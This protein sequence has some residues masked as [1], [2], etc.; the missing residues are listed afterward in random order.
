MHTYMIIIVV[1]EAI[2]GHSR[3]RII[4]STTT[5]MTLIR[6]AGGRPSPRRAPRR[7]RRRR[8][9]AGRLERGPRGS[10][11]GIRPLSP[12]LR[13]LT[14]DLFDRL[15]TPRPED[16]RERGLAVRFGRERAIQRRHPTRFETNTTP[17]PGV[18][19]HPSVSFAP[20][21]GASDSARRPTRFET[22]QPHGRGV[23]PHSSASFAPRGGSRRRA[24]PRVCTPGV[25]RSRGLIRFVNP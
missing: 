2:W 7:R 15:Q 24:P 6:D 25:H 12:R 13:S 5:R 21:E 4:R 17:W 18:P 1:R 14:A 20:R 16:C 19:P 10:R 8:G 23:P 22:T 9:G 3:T 11:R